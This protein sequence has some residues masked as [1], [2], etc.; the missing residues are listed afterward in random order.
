M[1]AAI[2]SLPARPALAGNAAAAEALFQEGRA[3]MEAGDYASACPKLAESDRQDPGVGTLLALGVCWEESGRLASAWAT[4]AEAAARA[5]RAGQTER[6]EAARAQARTLEPRLSRLTVVVSDETAALAGVEV[7]RDGEV[8]G[9]AGWGAGVPIDPGEHE[10]TATA[11]GHRP[12]LAKVTIG[13]ESD[14][15]RVEVPPLAAVDPEG[16]PAAAPG[17]ADATADAGETGQGPPLRLIGL[18]VG[19][20][21][22]IGLGLG[23]FFGLRAGALNDESY[24]NDHCTRNEECDSVGAGKRDDARSAANVSTV[25]FIAGGVLT[26]AGVTLYLLGGD[27][28]DDAKVSATAAFGPGSGAMV[29]R[30]SFQ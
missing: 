28:E 11:P 23:T 14:Q 16:A 26:A 6:E 22:I 1:A 3:L 30:G 2:C 8:V 29:V 10:I 25:A 19:G 15:Q 12:F 9:S 4:F 7:R 17:G 20:A 27:E 5:K 18:G 13:A 21:G 24:E